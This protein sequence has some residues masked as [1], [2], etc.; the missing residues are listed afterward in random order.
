[1]PSQQVPAATAQPPQGPYRRAPG[2]LQYEI[3]HGPSFAMLRVDL[4]PGGTVVAES[5]AMVARHQQVG[6]DVKLNASR[7]PGFFAMLSSLF[8]AFVRKIVGGETF[9]VNH[10]SAAQGGSVWLAPSL[11]GHVAHRQLNGETI[12]LSTGGYL[13]H[14][15]DLRV[16]L[17]FGGLRALLA[18][19]GAFFLEVSG[20][21]ELFFNS[22]GGIEAI[23]V[24]G[25]LVVDN[26]HLVGFEGALDYRIINSSN[27][28]VGAVTS[29]EGL[30]CEFVGHGRVYIQ[31]RNVSAL[32]D[33]VNPLLHG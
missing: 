31:S 32:A 27:S 33:Y 3:T 25:S 9:F 2:P 11:S 13:A 28:I 19:E 5:G 23:D 17:K 6:M 26:G 1:M 20:H 15:G 10:F 7:S 29:G 12:T 30:A 14:A 4:P 16:K 18:K 8:V 21:G 24:E 22:Y